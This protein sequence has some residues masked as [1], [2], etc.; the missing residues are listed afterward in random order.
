VGTSV[1]HGPAVVV[2]TSGTVDVAGTSLSPGRG[3]FVPAAAGPTT[4]DGSG[5]A[6]TALAGSDLESDDV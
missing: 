3:A 2:C 1:V 5:E 4:I 6:F